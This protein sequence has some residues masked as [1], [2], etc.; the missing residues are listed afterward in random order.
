MSIVVIQVFLERM[1]LRADFRGRGRRLALHVG[2]DGEGDSGGE[3]V[4][5]GLMKTLLF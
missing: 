4:A 3:G 2:C 1:P 5:G